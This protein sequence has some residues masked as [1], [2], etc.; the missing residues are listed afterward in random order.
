MRR[1][2]R[3]A[4][5]GIGLLASFLP[6]SS[7]AAFVCTT[8]MKATFISIH[9]NTRRVAWAI[10][11]PGSLTVDPETAKDLIQSSFRA[12]SEPRCTDLSFEFRGVVG[13]EVPLESLSQV[14]FI[15]ENWQSDGDITRDARAVALTTMHYEAATG[16]IRYG[17]IEVNEIDPAT[18]R[19]DGFTFAD[20]A[21][22]CPDTAAMDLRAV[23]TH[24]VGHFIG[25][26]HT[27]KVLDDHDQPL[28]LDRQPTMTAS[29]LPCDIWFRTLEVD[30]LEGLCTIYPEGR[31]ARQCGTLPDQQGSYVTSVP[32][33]CTTTGG[34][35]AGAF[36][37]SLLLARIFLMRR[38]GSEA[39]SSHR[40][41]R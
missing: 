2:G 41:G 34:P 4:W 21:I 31:S 9:W 33:G 10:Q 23:L 12:W 8:G 5:F 15:H 37:I 18:P 11:A 40:S 25:L 26:A 3:L 1:S 17:V 24:E 39:C 19:A 16:I 35:G 38:R 27:D 22:S 29:V 32:F 7:A 30:D 20:A 6:I 36:A 14:R 28:T 13:L